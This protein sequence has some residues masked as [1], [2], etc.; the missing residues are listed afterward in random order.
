MIVITT[1]IQIEHPPSAGGSYL[2]DFFR[3]PRGAGGSRGDDVLPPAV[4]D[5]ALMI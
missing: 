1:R 3:M 5:V 4:D 2:L